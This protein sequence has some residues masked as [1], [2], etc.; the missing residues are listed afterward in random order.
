MVSTRK[1]AGEINFDCGFPYV[2]EIGCLASITYNIWTVSA[3]IVRFAGHILDY[4]VYY[5]TNSTSYDNVFINKG[6]GAV[7]D[8]ANIF[9]IVT[10][11]YIAIKTV[12]SLDSSGSKKMISY[13]VIIALVIN[14]SLF[15]TKVVIDASNILAKYFTTT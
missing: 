10:L 9:F 3:N 11:L 5:S 7:R 12:L 15:T 2:L 14:F 4:F 1:Q 8:V 13:V 6:W